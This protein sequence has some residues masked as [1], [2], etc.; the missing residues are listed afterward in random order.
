MFEVELFDSM[1]TIPTPDSS[2]FRQASCI[3][4]SH[5]SSLNL[6][7]VC[8]QPQVGGADCGLFAIANVVDLCCG[9]DPSTE[10]R[11]QSEM[12]DHLLSYFESE[13]ISPFPK[14][15]GMAQGDRII[16]TVSVDIYCMCRQ[17]EDGPMARCAYCHQWYHDRCVPIPS[18]VFS[19]QDPCWKCPSCKI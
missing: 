5:C 13:K 2:I 6:S 8:V 16:K 9:V 4:K 19:N 12:R 7:V 18:A 15:K 17:P 10:K 3:A 14:K 11:I 1:F